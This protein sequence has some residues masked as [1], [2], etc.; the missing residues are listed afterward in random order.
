MA[1]FSLPSSCHRI[2]HSDD[3]VSFLQ[4][5]GPG[6]I[7]MASYTKPSSNS[8][9]QS[10]GSIPGKL[11]PELVSKVAAVIKPRVSFSLHMYGSSLEPL[12]VTRWNW[13]IFADVCGMFVMSCYYYHDLPKTM[14][15]SNCKYCHIW[16]FS[17]CNIYY[18]CAV[19]IY[20]AAASK[21]FQWG[22]HRWP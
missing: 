3:Y 10:G 22:C 2:L 14:I 16:L 5:E 13:C 7:D 9:S 6:L 11:N 20:T 4:Q 15:F 8:S 17:S 1:I 21:K 12:P 19:E 18:F